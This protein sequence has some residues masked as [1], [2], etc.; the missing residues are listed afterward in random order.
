MG[1]P[2]D[3]PDSFLFLI[4]IFSS[5]LF[6]LNRP[7]VT[8]Y[9]FRSHCIY[10]GYHLLMWVTNMLLVSSLNGWTLVVNVVI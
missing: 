5:F 8:L 6:W 3:L 2:F 9:A 10:G 1:L 7:I 4:L